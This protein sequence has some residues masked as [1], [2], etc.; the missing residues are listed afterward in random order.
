[1]GAPHRMQSLKKV[2]FQRFTCYL[3][4]IDGTFVEPILG[5]MRACDLDPNTRWHLI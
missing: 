4:V 2:H 3:T 1:M 5:A